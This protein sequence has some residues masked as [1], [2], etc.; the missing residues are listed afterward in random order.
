MIRVF[1]GYD[2]REAV[3]YHVLAHSILTR[4]SEPVAI[5]PLRRGL[6]PF[7]RRRREETESTDFSITRFLVPFLCGYKG[8]AVFMDCDMLCQG[9]VVELIDLARPGAAVSV[10]QHDYQTKA[11]TKFLGNTNVDYSRKNWSSLMVFDC[12]HE[13]SRM[14]S[15]YEVESRKGLDLHR[16][17]WTEAIGSLP[18]EW[19]WLVGEYEDNAGAQML[20]YTLGGPWFLAYA[21]GPMAGHW[22]A[23]YDRMR[24]G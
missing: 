16:F 20:H 19:N 13:D 15:L 18:V 24:G 8:K 10:V 22:W 21:K 17:S 5:I 7:F 14:L 11:E 2:D 6:L 12:E 9:D 23:E 3:A 1:I 4:A